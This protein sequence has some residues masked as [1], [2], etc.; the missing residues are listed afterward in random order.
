MLAPSKSRKQGW[1]AVNEHILKLIVS[2]TWNFTRTGEPK[3][4]LYTLEGLSNILAAEY[5]TPLPDEKLLTAELERTRKAIE[6]RLTSPTDL[7]DE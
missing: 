5:Q 1:Q 6:N 2:V 7:F 3:F 4:M